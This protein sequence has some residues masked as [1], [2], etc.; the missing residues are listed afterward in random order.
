MDKKIA[1]KNLKDFT[2]ILSKFT[3]KWFL[4]HGSCLGAVRERAIIGHDLDTDVGIMEEDFDFKMIGE[5]VRA[6]F[7]V[8]YI[9]GMRYKGMEIAFERDDVKTDLSLYYTKD[10]KVYT[11]FWE[12]GGR[13]GFANAIPMIFDKKIFL[14]RAEF[15]LDGIPFKTVFDFEGYLTALYGDWRTP[16]KKWRWWADFKNINKEFKI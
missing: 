6:G 10:D 3:D 8:K 14:G 1:V 11:V 9:F 16:V 15:N 7:E 13:D 12:N 5:L 4:S 2:D